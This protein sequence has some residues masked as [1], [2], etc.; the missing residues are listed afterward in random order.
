[1]RRIFK[2]KHTHILFQRKE[3]LQIMGGSQSHGLRLQMIKIFKIGI[4]LDSLM[5][6]EDYYV[7]YYSQRLNTNHITISLMIK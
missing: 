6:I 1:M 3:Q 5:E 7:K 2:Y 4:L